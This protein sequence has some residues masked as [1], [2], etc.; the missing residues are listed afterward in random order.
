[1][2]RCR[3]V[4]TGLGV[5]APNGTGV[6][7]FERALR[8][9]TSGI[10]HFPRLQELGFSCQVGGEP[11]GIDVL[12]HAYFRPDD[13]LAMNSNM[14]Y[15]SIAAVDAWRDAGL[16]P[17]SDDAPD[18]DSGAVI[19]TGLG[20]A[21]TFGDRGAP[22]IAAGKVRRLGSTLVE[23]IM[24]SSPSAKV[25]GLLGL[26]NQVTSNSSACA[27]GTEAIMLG[28]ERLRAG[29]ATRMIVGGSEGTSPYLWGAFDAMRVLDRHHNDAPGEA[30]RP[31]S[32]SAGGF[33]PG[34]G[35]GLLVLETLDSARA[36]GARVHAEVLGGAV[37]CGGQRG[38]GSM[39]APNP[40]AVR[41]CIRAALGDA[42]VDP[43]AIDAINGHLT[44]TYADPLE[45]AAWS[46]ALERGPG[47][48]PVVNATKSLIGHGLGAAG[49]MEAVACVL[50][51]ARGFVHGSANCEDLHAAL[52][53]FAASIPHRAVVPDRL[54]VI[55]KAG[56]GFGDV[57]AAV[58]FR[59]FE[60]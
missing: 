36:R 4:V 39:T 51:L 55:A 20:G 54:D 30:S 31:M 28:M 15:A 16:P 24:G 56:F 53:P 43:G 57:N 22:L 42:E 5:V 49:G 17:P 52:L 21:D 11:V 44:G 13:L 60:P 33:V 34:S 12:K 45:I 3:V 32:A 19:G 35:A 23:Q 46:D 25:A 14:L 58:I 18:P 7:A 59:R 40:A 6:A 2:A 29:R 47:F 48:F 1:M 26:G 38:G 50:Q 37:N 27:T 8:A 41:A 10:R 9:G